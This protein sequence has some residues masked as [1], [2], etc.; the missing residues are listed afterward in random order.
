ME[1]LGSLRTMKGPNF[2]GSMDK[3]TKSIEYSSLSD[4]YFPNNFD[5]QDIV[6]NIEFTKYNRKEGSFGK[7]LA[8]KGCLNND[9]N[10]DPV[11][12]WKMYGSQTPNLQRVAIRILSLTSSSSGC[13]KNLSTFEGIHTKKRNRLD[14]GRLNNL[15]YVKFNVELMNRHKRLRDKEKKVEVLE[16][17]VAINAYEWLVD[18]AD[19][20]V[21]LDPETDDDMDEEIEVQF[22]SDEECADI[23]GQGDLD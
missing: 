20:E 21:E 1:G 19:E 9:D 23:L 10:Y 8:V 6:V 7:P 18:D 4:M 16:A 22:K 3:F 15:V 17:S 5:M 11:Q 2:L 12:W 14:V 13:E